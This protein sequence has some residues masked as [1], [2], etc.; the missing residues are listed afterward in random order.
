MNSLEDVKIRTLKKEDLDAIV[1]IDEKV[2]GEN[3]KNYWQRKLELMNNKSS[4][5]SLV[6]EVEGEVV[7][8]ILGDVSGWEF[9]VPETIGW[10]DTIGVDPIYQKKGLAT[11]LAHELIKNLKAFEVKTIYTLV[12]WNDWDLLQFFH[13]MG[14]TRGDM[15]NLELKI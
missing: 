12:S 8:F 14:F 15:I 5:I 11:A 10:I 9:G 6:A 2:L 4:Q 1:E 3:R 7:G 13:A